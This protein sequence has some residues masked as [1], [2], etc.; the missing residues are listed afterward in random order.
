MTKHTDTYTELANGPLKLLVKKLGLPSPVPLRRFSQ[1]AYLPEPVLV[2]GPSAAADTYA[3]LLLDNGFDVRRTPTSEKLSAVLAFLDE[4]DDPAALS[5]T[6]LEVGGALR[7]LVRCARVITFSRTPGTA[8][9]PDADLDPALAA[10]RNGVTGLTRS[11][12]HEMRAGG[13]ANGIVVA[14][15]VPM[16]APSARAA[17][18]FLLSSKSAY[19]SGQFLEIGSV[20]GAELSAQEFTGRTLAGRTAVVTGAARGIGAA[21]AETLAREGATVHGV[22]VPQ[23]GDALAATM[24]RVGGRALQLDI[25]AADAASAIASH[26]GGPVDILVNNAGITRDRMLANMDAGRWDSVLEVNIGAQLRLNAGLTEAGAWGSSPHVVSLASI[27]GIAGNRGQTNYAASKAGV[28]G[29][30]AAS[31]GAFAAL[32]GS[33]NAVAPGFIETEMT[34]KVPVLTRELGRRVSSLQQGGLPQD[35]A[36]AVAFLASDA[37]GG[38]NG[39]TLRVCGQNMMGA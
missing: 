17:L 38:I 29:M 12:A 22:D 19:V 11:L 20:V 13:T 35:V 30:T 18:W 23:A 24:N 5:R 37:A 15:G 3:E 25:T 21:I 7:S 31:A 26:V 16:D 14:D 39:S 36:E 32:G 28:I 8:Q 6:A 1:G 10:A 33:V 27:S 4:A 34:K 2:L 9:H